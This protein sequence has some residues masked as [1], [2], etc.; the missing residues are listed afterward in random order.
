MVP[1]YID[2]TI[3]SNLCFSFHRFPCFQQRAPYVADIPLFVIDLHQNMP[4]S[5]FSTPFD[6]FQILPTLAVIPN[7]ILE[8]CHIFILLHSWI[9][10]WTNEKETPPYQIAPVLSSD[11]LGDI[12]Q[13]WGS[14]LA[15]YMCFPESSR[16]EKIGIFLRKNLEYMCWLLNQVRPW[17]LSLHYNS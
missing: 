15:G 6:H 10:G 16:P 12:Q 13:L 2:H 3:L 5:Q 1:P 7:L 14:P 8:P 9:H 17:V 4:I 11:V